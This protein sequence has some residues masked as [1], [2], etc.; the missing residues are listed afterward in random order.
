MHTTGARK[1]FDVRSQM[2]NP[3]FFG[4]CPNTKAGFQSD[5]YFKIFISDRIIFTDSLF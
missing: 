5:I 2:Q 3:S 1:Q 4:S